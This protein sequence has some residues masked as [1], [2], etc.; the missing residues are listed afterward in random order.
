VPTKTTLSLPL[1]SWTGEKKYDERLEGRVLFSTNF[2]NMSPSHRLQ[3]FTN[4]PRVGPF[5]GVQS[6]RN[7]LPQS[8]SLPWGA[9]LQ[10]QAAPEWVPH[11]VTSPASKPAPV[12]ASLF[13]ALQV[14]ATVCS[15]ADSQWGHTVLQAPTCS[16]MRSLPWATSGYLLHRGPPRTA[17]G[18][19]D[20]PR[21]SS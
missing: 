7:R 12:W 17:G 8:G 11:R 15:S 13:M 6:F 9:V 1:L 21:S 16:G 3:L 19:P 5:H 18:Q 20:S 14:L 2:C 4:C 10:E